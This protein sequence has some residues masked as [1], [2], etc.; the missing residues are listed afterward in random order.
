MR[1]LFRSFPVA[2]SLLAA[3]TSVAYIPAPASF[4]AAKQ[5]AHITM[6]A[7][8]SQQTITVQAPRMVG[9]SI[10]GSVRG[11]PAR[12]L[13]SEATNVT[14]VER[15][16]AKTVGL[17]L[18]GA[19]GVSGLVAYIATR[20]LPDRCANVCANPNP[21]PGCAIPCPNSAL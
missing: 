2:A 15:S 3:C 16:T 5:P 10:F 7:R 4:I 12:I 21:P 20:P 17:I 13:L 18:I 8:G 11:E 6:V 9:D 1:S 19:A 14:A